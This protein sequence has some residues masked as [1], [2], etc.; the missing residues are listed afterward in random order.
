MTRN[1]FAYGS[2]MDAEQMARRCPEATALGVAILDGWD[3]AINDRGVATIVPDPAA[4]VEGVLWRVTETCLRALDRYEGVASGLYRR[5]QLALHGEGGL[6]EATVYVATSSEPG[7]P[8]AGYLESI[9]AG[10]AAFGLS[11]GYR[12]RLEALAGQAPRF[13]TT[14]RAMEA[15][16]ARV[17]QGEIGTA[18]PWGG[19]RVA[20]ASKTRSRQ[21][22]GFYPPPRFVVTEWAPQLS[23]AFQQIAEILWTAPFYCF[24]TK[25]EIF[26]RLADAADRARATATTA[27]QVIS[28]VTSEAVSICRQFELASH[29]SLR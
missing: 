24:E 2:N 6:L 21:R 9:L 14:R 18:K 29:P 20:I 17:A 12:R 13:A 28:A 1:Y 22:G 3:V 27:Q 11:T 26:A 19:A 8:R 25:F 5:E 4:L 15:L 23:W 7:G 16:W 10:A